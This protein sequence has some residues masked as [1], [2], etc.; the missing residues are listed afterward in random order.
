MRLFLHSIKNCVKY[1]GILRPETS[2]FLGLLVEEK[3]PRHILFKI[4]VSRYIAI[5]TCYT[6][7]RGVLTHLCKAESVLQVLKFGSMDGLDN[8]SFSNCHTFRQGCVLSV[9]PFFLVLPKIFLCLAL[10][11]VVVIIL[12]CHRPNLCKIK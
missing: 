3:V 10:C 8:L 2:I 12:F 5:C 11:Y 1:C 9:F 7:Y 6:N 4:F